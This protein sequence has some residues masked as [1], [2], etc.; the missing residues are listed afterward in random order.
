MEPVLN[1]Y[2]Q[3]CW[4]VA[5]ALIVGSFAQPVWPVLGLT[6]I[7][8]A[9]IPYLAI[10]RKEQAEKITNTVKYILMALPL[11][12]VIACAIFIPFWSDGYRSDR[13]IGDVIG[14]INL[15]IIAVF[16]L[17]GLSAVAVIKRR[18]RLVAAGLF[19]ANLWMLLICMFIGIMA[20]A[21]SWI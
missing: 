3:F 8:F 5:Q 7:I 17:P 11:S 13:T 15:L 4:T 12:W 6:P 14:W 1:Y 21:G 2:Q 16:A 19:L 9:I 20:V 18:N 10:K